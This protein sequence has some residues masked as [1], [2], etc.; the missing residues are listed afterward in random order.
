MTLCALA[1]LRLCVN[2]WYCLC[3]SASTERLTKKIKTQRHREH[4][5]PPTHPL[6]PPCLCVSNLPAPRGR[7]RES[8]LSAI[9]ACVRTAQQKNSVKDGVLKCVLT[10]LP[11][12]IRHRPKH[13]Q[14]CKQ[15]RELDVFGNLLR[16]DHS[17]H[18]V[19]AS[20]ANDMSWQ[21]GAALWADR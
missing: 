7:N 21:R 10:G 15:P 9:T 13:D 1:A 18:V 17:A 19:A 16:N 2:F 8:I 4:R 3:A 6:W 12:Q 14:T 20:R 11:N 5:V